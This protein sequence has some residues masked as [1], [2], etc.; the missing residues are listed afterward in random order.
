MT[1]AR[2][3]VVGADNGD[4]GEVLNT[5]LGVAH[6]SDGS[7]Q[8]SA[9]QTAGGL[10]TSQLGVANGVASLNGTG[11]IPTTQLGSGTGGTS[12]YLRGD[13]SWVALSGGGGSSS[14]QGDSDVTLTS[15][16]NNQ[17]LTYN[18]TTSMWV[19]QTTTAAQVGA[20]S[21][22]ANLSTIAAANATSGTVGMAGYKITS[23]GN[24]SASTDAAAFGQIPT[25]ASSIG[26]LVA[27]NNLSDVTSATTARG[28]LGLGTASTQNN[29]FFLQS[30]NNLSDVADAG[31]S[32]A[33]IH[34]PALTPAACV[35]TSNVTLSGFQTIDGYTLASG[36]LVLLTGQATASQNGL[37]NAAN[38]SWTRPTEFATGTNIK[39]RTCAVLNGTTYGSSSWILNAP[40]A[41]VTVDTSS[42][43]WTNQSAAGGGGGSYVASPTS[44]T[45]QEGYVPLVLSPSGTTQWGMPWEFNVLGYGAK[46]NGVCVTDGSMTSGS[47]VLTC[48][49]S[50]P[51]TSADVGKA[52][53]VKYATTAA[54]GSSL[55]TTIAS[56]QSSS[57]VTLSASATN[58]VSSATVLYG[59]DDTTAFQNAVNAAVTYAQAHAYYAEV[60]VPPSNGPFYAI[61]GALQTGGSTLGNSQITLPV[62]G[63]TVGKVTLVLKGGEDAA[64]PRYWNQTTPA[65]NGPSLVSFGVFTSA[66]LQS[67]SINNNGNPAM[68]GGPSGKNGYGTSA[69][70]FSNMLL[71]VKGL[72]LLT[73]HSAD[74]FGYSALNLHGLACAN[75]FDISYGT[76]G[77]VL[78]SQGGGDFNVTGT[79]AAGLS[80]GILMPA[81]GNNDSNQ[82][83]NIICQGGYTYGFFA[84]EH[85]DIHGLTMLYCWS[86]LCLVGDYGDS[87]VGDGALHA[88]HATQVS[89]EA[90]SYHVNIIGQGT[91]EPTF[92]GSLDTEGT[93]EI[94]DTGLVGT[95]QGQFLAAA[96]GQI[97]LTGSVSTINLTGGAGGS[98]TLMRIITEQQAP[99]PVTTPTYTLGTAQINAFWRYATV[100]VTGGTGTNLTSIQVSEYMGGTTTPALTTIYTQS[101]GSLPSMNFRLSPGQWWVI[102]TSGSGTAPTLQWVLD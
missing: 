49:T 28:N 21:S 29:S 47:A 97:T 77:V 31:S 42:Q 94:R 101:G 56:F 85:T 34:I 91:N 10:T 72:S 22:S 95:T 27:S 80:I 92:H 76:I 98:G 12:T 65:F 6:N 100:Y 61:A 63:P 16:S 82:V 3:P 54:T 67:T 7:L 43:T 8:A 24:G 19:N 26:G 68:I 32:R 37:W 14:L 73:T 51:F 35:T 46:G 13:G 33:N 83:R 87:G 5:F 36:D 57:Q 89:I 74:G 99:G 50:T 25:T 1:A 90:C 62:I 11:H 58:T 40:T 55:V 69:L 48:S 71:V 78:L 23:L 39:G 81:A 53:M 2:L 52:I 59:T 96:K 30:S 45:D 15:P 17:V 4:W 70:L 66:S 38:G 84:T 18:G 79:F 9:L 86:G 60:V 44:T 75:L 41:G 102:N 93:I 88:I 20:L 64:G